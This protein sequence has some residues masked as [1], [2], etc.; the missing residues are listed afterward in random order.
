[1][2]DGGRFRRPSAARRKYQSQKETYVRKREWKL[3]LV[4]RGSNSNVRST[5]PG[6]SHGLPRA[7]SLNRQ[8]GHRDKP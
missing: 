5:G 4:A 1:M 7:C 3:D 8:I 2:A 6:Q